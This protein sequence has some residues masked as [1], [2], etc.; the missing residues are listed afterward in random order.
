VTSRSKPDVSFVS[1]VYNRRDG[2]FDDAPGDD[3]APE[4]EYD[5]DPLL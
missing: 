3:G 4:D 5:D 1:R 2:Q